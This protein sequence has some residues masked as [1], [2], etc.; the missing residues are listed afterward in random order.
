[1]I[2]VFVFIC[3]LVCLRLFLFR[4]R[5]IC[6]AVCCVQQSDGSFETMLLEQMK[7]CYNIFRI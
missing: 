4:M 6:I 7:I 2:F 1:M 5:F 3:L